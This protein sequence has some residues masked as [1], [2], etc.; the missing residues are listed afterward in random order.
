MAHSLII[1]I[2]ELIENI[3]NCHLMG[4]RVRCIFLDNFLI[5]KIDSE[6]Y[7]KNTMKPLIMKFIHSLVIHSH[8]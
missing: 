5:R 8:K 4:M 7:P 2:P 3:S 6:I 1:K